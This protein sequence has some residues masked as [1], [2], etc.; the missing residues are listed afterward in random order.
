MDDAITIGLS[1]EAH[2]M[3]K[4]LKEE[5]LFNEMADCYRFAV[6]LAIERNLDVPEKVGQRQTIFNVGTLDPDGDLRRMIIALRPEAE[7]SPYRY[8]E[9]LAEVG[10]REVRS[11]T[12]N[13][14]GE[15]A[16]VSILT[17]VRTSSI[18]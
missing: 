8:I 5:G 3:L 17:A 15:A 4:D 13:E 9:R 2:T 10:V 12:Q 6:A 14:G 18:E 11:V 16:L 1:Q 7:N